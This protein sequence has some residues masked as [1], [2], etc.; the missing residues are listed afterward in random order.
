MIDFNDLKSRLSV[1]DVAEFLNL[2]LKQEGNTYRSACPACNAGGPRAI[3]LFSD[4]NTFKCYPSDKKGG[5]I[6]GLVAHVKGIGVRQ[7]GEE[8]AAHFGGKEYQRQT[9]QQP[10][11]A[12]AKPAPQQQPVKGTEKQTGLAPIAHLDPKHEMVKTVGFDPEAAEKLGVGYAAK[13]I[14]KGTVGVPVRTASG[15]LVGYLGLTT[16]KFPKAWKLA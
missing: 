16:A 4:T 5:D 3:E 15:V 12:Q 6:I 8:L 14:L 10:A 2:T 13:G 9:R 1:L 11:P 7:A